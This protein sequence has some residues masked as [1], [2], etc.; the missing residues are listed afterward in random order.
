MPRKY[1]M[2]EMRMLAEWLS[3]NYLDYEVRIREWLGP[4]PEAEELKRAGVS[5]NVMMP[6]GGGWADAIILA[7]DWTR[8]VEACVILDTRHVGALEGYVKLF[9]ATPRYSSRLVKPVIPVLLYAYP[10]KI[11]YDM[12]KEKGFELVEYRKPWIEEYLKEVLG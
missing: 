10:R 7:P 12:A 2:V 6:F 1:R 9:K 3:E 11:A 8:I 5:P 4:T